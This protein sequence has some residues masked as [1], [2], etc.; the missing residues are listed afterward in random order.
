MYAASLKIMNRKDDYVRVVLSL[1]AKKK[2]LFPA[3]SEESLVGKRPRAEFPWVD[4][5][6]MPSPEA[7]N[8]VCSYSDQLPYDIQTPLDQYFRISHLDQH[9][10]LSDD[11][12]GFSLQITVRPCLQGALPRASV[13]LCLYGTGES[14]GSELWLRSHPQIA[15]TSPSTQ[16]ALTSNVRVRVQV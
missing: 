5:D 12:D 10:I 6:M 14:E 1:L 16:V 15:L 13:S 2:G 8:D 3:L 7:F 9:I 4:E 11:K